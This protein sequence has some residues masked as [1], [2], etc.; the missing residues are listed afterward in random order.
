VEQWVSYR[1]DANENVDYNNTYT[2]ADVYWTVAEVFYYYQNQT[3]PELY[4]INP[5]N[6]Q[7]VAN[8]VYQW[9]FSTNIIFVFMTLNG[10]WTIGTY[11][12]WIHM[13]RKSEL[14]Q[15]GRR[16]G[17]YRATVDLVESICQDLGN[18][19]CAYSEKELTEKLEKQGGIKYY[20]EQ[21]EGDGISH[22]GITSCRGRGPVSL[23]FGEPYVRAPLG[24]EDT[25]NS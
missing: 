21:G 8:G 15:K 4:L 24:P 20:V 6:V 3:Y 5:D 23:R 2:D 7:C 25:M 11:G 14:C 10:L 17:K 1:K 16:L 22:I 19:I 13:N 9:G 18:D 12:V